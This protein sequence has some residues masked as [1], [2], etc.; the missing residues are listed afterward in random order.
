MAKELL[1]NEMLTDA[2]IN[3]GDQLIKQMDTEKA[4]VK[5]AFWF[6]TPEENTWKLIVVSPK[7]AEEGHRRY[8]KRVIEANKKLPEESPHVSLNDISV[9]SV[10][11]AIVQLLMTIKTDNS[12]NNLRFSKNTV[13]GH[14]IDDVYIYR[15]Q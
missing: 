11:D 1:V 14:F 6:Y 8:Y 2:M 15:M 12:I 13:N 5:S 10:D 9:S 4:D 7:V 3:S